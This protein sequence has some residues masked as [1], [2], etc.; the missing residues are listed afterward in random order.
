MLAAACARAGLTDQ[1]LTVIMQALEAVER[2]G[3]LEHAAEFH[4]QKGELT[5]QLAALEAASEAE[6][7]FRYAIEIASRQQAKSW[8]LRA[9]ISL[10]RLWNDQ[11]KRKQAREL[12][13][14]VNDWF[15]EGF[16]TRDLQ[17]AKALLEALA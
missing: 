7:C 16:D 11:G 3:E 2:A 17:D 1:A 4:R 5:L 6:K 9:A 14:P 8:E 13:A 15:T 12:L 10:A